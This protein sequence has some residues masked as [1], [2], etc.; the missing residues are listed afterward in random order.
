GKRALTAAE[1]NFTIVG[2]R[3]KAGTS[4]ELDIER[5]RAEVERARQTLVNAEMSYELAK[6]ALET[7]SGVKPTDGN[8]PALDDG[9][10]NE[11]PLEA[12]EPVVA[13]LPSVRAAKLETRAAEKTADAAWSALL[14]T[15][16]GSATEKLTTAPGFSGHAA[17]WAIVFTAQWTLDASLYF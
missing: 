17:S 10:A 4:S 9:L 8:M 16:T 12:F 11:G 5:S 2:Q 13:S 3:F 1:D 7:A 14:P 15:I 6:R